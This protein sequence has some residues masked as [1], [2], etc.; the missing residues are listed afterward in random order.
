MQQTQAIKQHLPCLYLKRLVGVLRVVA[1][2]HHGELPP[3][4]QPTGAQHLDH[5]VS[6]VSTVHRA[7]GHLVL[8]QD[9]LAGGAVVLQAARPQDGPVLRQS[10]TT[11]TNK[12]HLYKISTLH[13]T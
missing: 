7:A 12:S 3:G 2:V 4:A 1:G 6:H 10:V 9:R 13:T 11:W 5:H 8:R